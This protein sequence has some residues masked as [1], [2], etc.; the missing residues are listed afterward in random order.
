MKKQL[1]IT[2]IEK[3][4]RNCYTDYI[5]TWA[6]TKNANVTVQEAKVLVAKTAEKVRVCEETFDR[7]EAALKNTREDDAV[8]VLQTIKEYR[9]SIQEFKKLYGK[10]ASE[11]NA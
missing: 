9:N 1:D 8:Y 4:V 2:E 10:Q 5:F 3:M 11:P 7:V 6:V